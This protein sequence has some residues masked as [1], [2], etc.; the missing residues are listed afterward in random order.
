MSE[1]FLFRAGSGT[2]RTKVA[3]NGIMHFGQVALPEFGQCFLDAIRD[4]EA[5]TVVLTI[6]QA[7]TRRIVATM[8][9]PTGSMASRIGKITVVNEDGKPVRG[10]HWKVIAT[11]RDGKSGPYQALKLPDVKASYDNAF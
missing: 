3:P 1:I 11:T 10:K 4:R 7:S 6:R 2:L 8:T 9:L 5:T